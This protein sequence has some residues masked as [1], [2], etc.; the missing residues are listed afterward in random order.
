MSH[1]RERTFGTYPSNVEYMPA[2][3]HFLA[4]SVTFSNGEQRAIDNII[5]CTGYKT[6]FPFLSVD[7]GI[8]VDEEL[9]RPLFKDCI[10]I[11]HPTM[12]IIGM[13][14]FG[15]LAAEIQSR[16]VMRFVNGE[17]QYPTK[18]YMKVDSDQH[19]SVEKSS[20]PRGSSEYVSTLEQ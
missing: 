7:C 3:E 17:M 12:A 6:V 13:T 4:D 8:S 10:N 16:F 5:Y 19:S 20:K 14:F 15:A 9:I 11:N 1:R 2:V 18:E